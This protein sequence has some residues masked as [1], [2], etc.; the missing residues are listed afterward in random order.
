[1][2]DLANRAERV[3]T[4]CDR[5]A[6]HLQK[7]EDKLDNNT[8]IRMKQEERDFARNVHDMSKH[9]DLQNPYEL[10][11]DR[12]AN[13]AVIQ[14][15]ILITLRS[16]DKGTAGRNRESSVATRRIRRGYGDPGCSV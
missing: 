7:L 4:I 13:S 16:N 12:G 1:M 15:T 6:A 5:A 9:A 14:F 8:I 3:A 10:N 2:H 11:I